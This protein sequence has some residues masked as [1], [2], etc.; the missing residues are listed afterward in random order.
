MPSS[1]EVIEK[2]E[3]AGWTLDRIKGSH[4]LFVH[5]HH[6]RPIPVPHPKKD[7]KRGTVRSMERQAGI[8]L[9]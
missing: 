5:P 1:R 9:W 7:L 3:A 8:P 4:H 2:L 6:A